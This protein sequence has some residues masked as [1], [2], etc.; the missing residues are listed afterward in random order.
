MPELNSIYIDDLKRLREPIK[1]IEV[2]KYR[3]SPSYWSIS[4]KFPLIKLIY[5][6]EFQ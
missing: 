2:S 3:N 1:T 5:P 6:F 4:L